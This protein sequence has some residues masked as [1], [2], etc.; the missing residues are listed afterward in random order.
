MKLAARFKFDK[1][2][3]PEVANHPPYKYVRAVHP[4]LRRISAWVSTLGAAAAMEDL[5]G[6]GLPNDLVYSDPR[7]DLVTV[8]P[9]PGTGNRYAP[10]MLNPAP[11]PY[12]ASHDGPDGDRH[13]RLQRRRF[14]GRAGVLLGPLAGDFPAQKNRRCRARQARR[15]FRRR[16]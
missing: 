3:L 8:A 2:P 11:L 15:H 4:S 1:L 12:D 7:T 9:V 13:W 14:D 6:D 5:D 16:L 10:F